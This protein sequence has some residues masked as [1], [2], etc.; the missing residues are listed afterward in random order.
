MD[1]L[2]VNSA[3]LC[4]G[5]CERNE[6][7]GRCHEHAPQVPASGSQEAE[8][9]SKLA[10]DSPR[11]RHAKKEELAWAGRS[12]QHPTAAGCHFHY[13]YG[14][15]GGHRWR[16]RCRGSAGSPVISGSAASRL[17]ST[18]TIV[19][20]AFDLLHLEGEDTA[21]LPLRLRRAKLAPLID[22]SGL[23][24]SIE[25]PGRVADIISTVR[26]M[27]L[28]GV[29]AKRKDSPYESGERSRNW[30]KLKLE[31][32][33][34]FVI[35]GYRPSGNSVDALLVGYFEENG[36]RFAA[37]VRAGLLPHTRTEL[38]RRLEELRL[39]DCPFVDLP[40]V[41][42]SR[43]GGGVSAED[44]KE[45][46]WT[47]PTM[48]AQIQFVEWTAEGRLRHARFLGLRTDKAAKD[49]RREA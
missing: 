24:L 25:L 41:G 48:V 45:I 12:S 38:G 8:L 15:L 10:S 18:H 43:W 1:V 3:N 31:R 46:I 16:D 9:R 17:E 30:Q 11:A 44:M 34:E 21:S 20:Y 49:V 6:Q 29:V 39:H 14:C 37:K 40:S 13:A 47:K 4:T 27:Q 33:Q 42:S 36:L 28:E 32:Q 19:F 5:Q 23:L 26:S 2:P 7:L 22:K 35:G